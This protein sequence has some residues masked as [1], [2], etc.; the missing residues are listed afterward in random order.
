MTNLENSNEKNS[1]VKI[2]NSSSILDETDH[3]IINCVVHIAKTVTEICDDTGLSREIIHQRLKKLENLKFFELLHSIINGK[4]Q[5]RYKLK[6][7]MKNSLTDFDSINNE[8]I[9]SDYKDRYRLE[10]WKVGSKNLP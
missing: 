10:K 4:K 9:S 8:K 1:F 2:E 6:Q 5:I 3:K 7:S